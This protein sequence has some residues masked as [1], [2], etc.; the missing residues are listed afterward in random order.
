MQGKMSQLF[1]LGPSFD[2]MKCRKCTSKSYPFFVIKNRTK[3]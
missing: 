1:D 3:A 2:F